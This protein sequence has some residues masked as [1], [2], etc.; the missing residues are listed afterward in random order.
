MALPQGAPWFRRVLLQDGAGVGA[1]DH[2]LVALEPTGEVAVGRGGHVFATR[3]EF[4]VGESHVEGALRDVDLDDVA[5]ADE[6]D[7]SAVGRF[8]AGMADPRGVR[9]SPQIPS[10]SDQFLDQLR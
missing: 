5:I 4:L 6:S 1:G 2:A 8:G 7:G 9:D 10:G 3:F